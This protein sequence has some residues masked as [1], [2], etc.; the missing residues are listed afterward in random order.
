MI[1]LL[2]TRADQSLKCTNL[3]NLKRFQQKQADGR[4][5]AN[6][7]CSVSV[8]RASICVEFAYLSM[9]I[10]FIFHIIFPEQS[11]QTQSAL[12]AAGSLTSA[13]CVTAFSV[14]PIRTNVSS[15]H[16]S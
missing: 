16:A 3:L 9:Y 11:R 10:I 12:G 7:G 6:D 13:R 4:P 15:N 5:S 14:K 8:C 2:I 1:E